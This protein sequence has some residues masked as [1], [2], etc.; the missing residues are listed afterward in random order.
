MS[1]CN[2]FKLRACNQDCNR[3]AVKSSVQSTWMMTYKT[4]LL[5]KPK[6][7]EVG[8]MK[9]ELL[10]LSFQDGSGQAEIEITPLGERVGTLIMQSSRNTSR[11]LRVGTPHRFHLKPGESITLRNHNIVHPTH[12]GAG[13]VA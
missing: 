10:V 5:A 6:E 4:R 13:M 1:E 11:V 9:N 12:A 3:I 8:L 2:G 7:Y